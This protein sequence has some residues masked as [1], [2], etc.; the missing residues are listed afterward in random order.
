MSN[1][2]SE[3][4]LKTG[5]FSGGIKSAQNSL[6]ELHG[7]V[8]GTKE[9]VAGAFAAISSSAVVIGLKK[10]FDVGNE[11]NN[12]SNATGA[13]VQDLMVLRQA[14]EENGI[15]A[16]KVGPSLGKL[17]KAIVSAAATGEGEAFR[18][19]G[20]NVKALGNMSAAD[21]MKTIG[22]AIMRI[23]NPTERSAYAM[24]LFG[25]NGQQ[26]LAMFAN[27]GAMEEAAS[28]IGNQA[29][30]LDENSAI[31]HDITIKLNAVGTKLQGF[32]VGMAAQ[33]APAIKPLTDAFAKMDFSKMGEQIGEAVAF[34]VTAFSSGN[35]STLLGDSVILSFE[36]AVNFLEA[37]LIGCVYA[38]GQLVIEQ[39][40]DG[41]M[42]L[43]I[44]TTA[45]FW[46]GLG[47]SIM[48]IAEGFIAFLLDGI[49]LL[50]EKMKSIPLVGEK[51]GKGA[52]AIN[53]EANKIREHGQKNRDA[54]ADRLAPAVDAIKQRAG[55]A[56]NNLG[57]AFQKGFTTA[58][59]VF[60]TGDT[61]KE[62][63]KAVDST[64]AAIAANKTA[65]DKFN[66][67]H[68]PGQQEPTEDMTEQK[69]MRLGPAFTSTLM[70]IG[71]GGSS[72][73]G[74]ADPILQENRRHTSLLQTIAK[75]TAL[76]TGGLT[77]GHLATFSL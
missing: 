40:R 63:D 67:E 61:Q 65:A 69:K 28:V 77:T 38:F 10:A 32:F 6:K 27:S 37:A 50:L 62:F 30:L 23:Q 9:I 51:I 15:E 49:A 70:K 75:N 35:L 8:I 22:E 52:Q 36:N 21:Q 24:Q 12:L 1:I 60:D 42:I 47:E 46:I 13:A 76:K 56:M 57:D 72:V 71:G 34:L 31:F 14:F 68:K 3:L 53:A 45:D 29:Q 39:F 33:I 18:K 17:R 55:E 66:E 41:L 4:I 44:A 16:E 48:G 5:L 7:S 43:Q 2:I 26:M 11:L 58:P 19:L 73:G 64:N 54:G 25:R 74:G 20:L 59:K